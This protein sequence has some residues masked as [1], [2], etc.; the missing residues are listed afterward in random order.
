[1][2]NVMMFDERRRDCQNLLILLYAGISHE[3]RDSPLYQ[4]KPKVEDQVHERH[5]YH[6]WLHVGSGFLF[7][8][9]GPIQG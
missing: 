8:A 6:G 2:L 1:M 3:R 7:A 9:V 4:R 5:Y